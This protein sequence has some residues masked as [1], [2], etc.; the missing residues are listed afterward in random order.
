MTPKQ[1]IENRNNNDAAILFWRR[2]WSQPNSRANEKNNTQ[3]V[4]NGSE[5]AIDLIVG[6]LFNHKPTIIKLNCET[7]AQNLPIHIIYGITMSK[8]P[9]AWNK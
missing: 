7:I 8:Y 3:Q 4:S 5:R 2:V 1:A 6:R 9:A